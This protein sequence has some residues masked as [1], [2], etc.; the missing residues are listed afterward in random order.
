M[1]RVLH[2][3]QVFPDVLHQL[4]EI[5]GHVEQV[6]ILVNLLQ[7]L[8]LV[9]SRKSVALVPVMAVQVY[10]WILCHMQSAEN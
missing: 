6:G 2:K 9:R 3:T 5:D 8:F 7:K 4:V 1:P 10:L